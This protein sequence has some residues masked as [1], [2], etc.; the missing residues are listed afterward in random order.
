MENVYLAV[1]LGASSGRVIAGSLKNGTP[2]MK[3]IHR[4]AN[5]QIKLGNHIYWNFLYLFSEIKLGLKKAAQQ[6]YHVKSIGID[7]WGVDFGLIDK[8][9]N[10][11]A[12]PVCYRDSRTTGMIE[13]VFSIYDEASYY[14]ETGSQPMLINT[15]FQLYSLLKSEDETLKVADKLLFMPDLVSYFL[16]GNANVEYC[17]ASTSG[18]LDA[19]QKDWSWDL[20]RRLKFPEK[21]F[22]EIIMPG[23][24]RGKL[25]PEIA[26]ET[27][28]SSDVEVIAVASHD[29]ASAVMG[30]P[31]KKESKVFLSSG[32]WSILGV[33]LEE[34]ILTEEARIAGFTNE[35]GVGSIRFLQNIT[36][37]WILQQLMK[38]WK[39]KNPALTYDEIISEAEKSNFAGIID[40]DD[41]VF[42]N[43]ENM[44]E[45]VKNFCV[46]N[47]LQIPQTRGDYTRCVLYSLAEKYKEK[48]ELLKKFLSEP[49]TELHII[50]GGSQNKMLNQL[51]ADKLNI[52]VIAG[53]VEA[54]ALGNLL[55]QAA[56]MGDL[57]KEKINE[58]VNKSADIKIYYPSIK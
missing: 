16:T 42:S 8:K 31:S 15:V 47:Q 11:L 43:P 39:E 20:I 18:I 52:T 37:L 3:E 45:A 41:K 36:G 21:I 38:K 24:K 51:V 13:D 58:M 5:G 53:P 54:T 28:L 30:V 46:E 49:V 44:E 56:A 4:F 6:G 9:G 10:L 1:D 35:G 22:G 50:G 48:F 34:P 33:T 14:A 17:I 55:I 32:T 57:R 29:T 7:T 27:G 40:V 23:S 12:N 26:A 19:K 2:E 25:K